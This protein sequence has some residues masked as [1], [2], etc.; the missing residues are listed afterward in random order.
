M[1]AETNFLLD[2]SSLMNFFTFGGMNFQEIKSNIFWRQNPRRQTHEL[3]FLEWIDKR[4]SDYF[5]DC[6]C[7]SLVTLNS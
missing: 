7:I 1:L 3:H 6:R 4:L 5:L 2:Q